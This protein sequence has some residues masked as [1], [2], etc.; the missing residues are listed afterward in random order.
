METGIILEEDGSQLTDECGNPIRL[1]VTTSNGLALEHN[2]INGGRLSRTLVV[3]NEDVVE[4]LRNRL[5]S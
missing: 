2:S 1:I 3:L 4:L 5:N